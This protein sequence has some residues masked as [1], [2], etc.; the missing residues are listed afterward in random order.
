MYSEQDEAESGEA[1]AI[2]RLW[3]HDSW[4]TRSG[5]TKIQSK[6]MHVKYSKYPETIFQ[7]EYELKDAARTAEFRYLI[8]NR[9]FEMLLFRLPAGRQKLG[10]LEL[11]GYFRIKMDKRNDSPVEI[12][13]AA[14]FGDDAKLLNYE[15]NFRGDPYKM[16]RPPPLSMKAPDPVTGFLGGGGLIHRQYPKMFRPTRLSV[17]VH[18]QY[19]HKRIHHY[20]VMDAWREGHQ[21]VPKFSLPSTKNQTPLPRKRIFPWED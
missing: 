5:R 16:A 19:P 14:F 7:L 13:R 6:F 18:H 4:K 17:P 8:E 12:K 3:T 15:W 20:S 11:K 21:S 10:G 1:L 2:W 9:V